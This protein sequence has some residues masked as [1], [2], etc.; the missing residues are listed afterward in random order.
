MRTVVLSALILFL[1]VPRLALPQTVPN[2]SFE[3]GGGTAPDGWTLT[4]PIGV[5]ARGGAAAGHRYLTVAGKGWE[6]NAWESEP[7]SFSVNA[8]YRLSFWARSPDGR[9][10]T[11]VSGPAFCNR[12]L[13]SL[14]PEWRRY[15]SI[16]FTPSNAGL[17]RAP[18]RLGQW[19]VKGAVH[20]DDVR[21]HRAEPMYAH[22][23]GM[24]LGEGEKIE[25]NG[26]SFHAPYGGLCR[27]HSRP[28]VG[29]RGAFNTN[30]WLFGPG[31]VVVYRHELKGRRQTAGRVT[32]GVTW[33]RR[34]TLFVRVSRDGK[35]WKQIGAVSSKGTGS[36]PLPPAMAGASQVWV[37]LKSG[38]SE[39]PWFQVGS[40]A[41][42]C[43]LDGPAERLSGMTRYWV[44]TRSSQELLVRM[45][46]LGSGLPGGP[47]QLVAM[48]THSA[49][50]PLPCRALIPATGQGGL[51]FH[52][53]RQGTRIRVPYEVS[54]TGRQNVVLRILAGSPPNERVVYEGEYAWHVADLYRADYGERLTPGHKDLGLWWCSSGWKVSRTRHLPKKT[55]HCLRI[56]AAQN[57]VEAVQLV[58]RPQ[59]PICG[60]R[61]EP[62]DLTG[63]DGA[64]IEASCVDVLRVGYVS[65]VHPT[66]ATGVVAD[67][68]DPLPPFRGPADLKAHENQPLWVRVKVPRNT[69]AG[70]YRGTVRLGAKGITHEVPLEVEVFDFVLP[71]RSTCT[72]AFGFSPRNVWRYQKVR[73]PAAKRAV[74]EKYWENFS[75]H[76]IS[77]YDPAPL[78]PIGVTWP[79]SSWQGGQRD[80]KVKHGGAS[81]LRVDD[82]SKTAQVQARHTPLLPIPKHGFVLTFWYRTARLGHRFIVTL[83]HHDKAG[84]WMSGRNN[85]MEVEG[86]ATW[87]RFERRIT[88]FPSEAA[89]VTLTL[90]AA[91]WR[92]DGSSVGTV[93]YDDVSLAQGGTGRELI[94]GGAFEPLGAK[95][96]VPRFNWSS[97][98]RAMDRA[99]GHYHF[100]SFRAR[101]P[102]LG[103]GTFHARVEPSL[104]G[105]GEGTPEYDTAFTN[106]CRGYETHLRAK[107]WLDRAFVYWFDEPAPRDYAFVM[108]G[109]EKLK[110]A[111][112]GLTRMLTE[113]VEEPLIGGPDVWCPVTHHYDHAKA[114]ARRKQG[115]TFWWYVCTGPKAPYCTLFIDHPATELRVWLWQT[116][117]RKITGVL[118]WQTNYWTSSAAYPEGLQNPYADPMGWMSGYSTP[119]GTRKPWGN[120]DGRFLYPPVAAAAG[121]Q[122]GPVLEGPVD[123]IRWE[124]LRD[125]VEDYEYLAVLARLLRKKG[126]SLSAGEKADY[127]ALLTVP[128]S[129]SQSL[130]SFTK[131]PRPIERR[132]LELAR[133][134]VAL[135]KE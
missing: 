30:R 123:S 88:A 110:K 117:K 112:P 120:G 106:F 7:L 47:N 97:W 129:I 90:W 40:Y 56:R 72:T 131:D 26:Y 64:R 61:A 70:L 22:G 23:A 128:P 37:A 115:E 51:R 10:G 109:F 1:A 48:V 77:P 19:C 4:G 27:N 76:R 75:A 68:P 124:M 84:S 21:L 18:I 46:D 111:A 86:D 45:E 85:D 13:R 28:L 66:D 71:D 69:K 63:P 36:F 60:F 130:T 133:A 102:G 134:I 33:Y 9:G 79:A 53:T 101:I 15:T 59:K 52:A 83:G 100:T 105:Y 121:A 65:V 82:R 41:Y 62:T 103:S 89:S 44:V 96:L 119:A 87:Q 55:A 132:R 92:E 50:T 93:W 98:D 67:W 25:G 16:F 95:D 35:A 127:E 14:S 49:E 54:A 39:E 11:P 118:V 17:A 57:E 2:P 80:G 31:T 94:T 122:D 34:G 3:Q 104:L 114:T 107:G 24:E 5:W 125:G 74:L 32:V 42:Q 29:F 58:V 38:A 8:T 99:M 113:Q 135:A 108:N 43:K 73:D 78:D 91:V 20:F 116:W 12:D 81:S 6:S 126:P